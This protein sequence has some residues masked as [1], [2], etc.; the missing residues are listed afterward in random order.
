[1]Y[2]VKVAD[3]RKVVD[4]MSPNCWGETTRGHE[5]VKLTAATEH[6]C[7]RFGFMFDSFWYA[8]EAR[9]CRRAYVTKMADDIS[10]KLKGKK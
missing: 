10:R 3:I 6:Q 5:T 7:Y 4:L 2:K 1:M 8:E 9:S